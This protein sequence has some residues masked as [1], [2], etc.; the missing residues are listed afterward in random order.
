MKEKIANVLF[1]GVLILGMVGCFK[2]L[3]LQDQHEKER[4]I[5]RCGS[6]ENLVEHY[7]KDGDIWWSCKVEK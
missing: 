6:E 5:A 2:L 3:A 1:F 4:A 7:T